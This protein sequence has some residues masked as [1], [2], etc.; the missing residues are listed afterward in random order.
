M[1]YIYQ[2]AGILYDICI[3]GVYVQTIAWNNGHNDDDNNTIIVAKQTA[4]G[5]TAFY[6]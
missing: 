6:I 4:F 5:S 2:I 1:V 3:I